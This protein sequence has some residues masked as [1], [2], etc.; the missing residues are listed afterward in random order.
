MSFMNLK[1]FGKN[2]SGEAL[3][4]VEQSRNYQQDHFANIEPTVVLR[5]EAS[6]FNL[7]KKQLNRPKDIKPGRL[8]PSVKTDLKNLDTK[9]PLII[10]FGHSS[11]LL[12]FNNFKIL[13]DPV[14]SGHASPF[15]GLVKSFEGSNIYS[16]ADLP[17][18]DLL[19]I[20]HDHYDH[21]DYETI[22][23]V[24]PIVRKIITP[25]GVG[26]HLRYWG[27][28][29]QIIT[30]V[31]W[32]D[33]VYI[34]DDIKLTATP[35]RHFSGRKIARGKSLWASFALEIYGHKIFIG[36]D[37]GYSEQ[38]RIIGEKFNSFDL[39]ILECG[40]YGVDW[41][42]IHMFPEQTVQ[43]AKDLRANILMPVHW[44]KFILSLHPWNE[45]IKRMVQECTNRDQKFIAPLIG[46]VVKIYEPYTQ[47]WWWNF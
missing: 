7:I 46:E 38:F 12:V 26:S 13:V 45:P 36:G 47:Q 39:A 2:P 18:I 8:L 5:K 27:F 37:S 24:Q 23:G 40:Q 9:D 31:D 1:V 14:F 15:K 17:E 4:L 41:P 10:W 30:E 16:V 33:E 42:M 25:L 3:R 6:Y 21:M 11:Y 19:I 44:G 29:D 20:T 34:N 43:A 28:E 35:A 32:W 22:M